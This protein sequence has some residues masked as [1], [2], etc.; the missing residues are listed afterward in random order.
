MNKLIVLIVS[1]TAIITN[2]AD[3]H[4]MYFLAKMFNLR[5]FCMRYNIF[6]KRPSFAQPIPV[7]PNKAHSSFND[8]VGKMAELQWL[9]SAA[10]RNCY[11]KNGELTTKGKAL[12]RFPD[13]S[14]LPPKIDIQKIP[15]EIAELNK[16]LE[17]S[18]SVK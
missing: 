18:C 15:Q 16:A 10:Q 2:N 1:L 9:L 8:I 11:D 17:K 4:G 3:L 14:S 7:Q 6:G 5:P 13:G 12:I